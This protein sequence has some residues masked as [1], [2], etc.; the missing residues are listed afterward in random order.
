MTRVLNRWLSPAVESAR[1]A[2]TEASG[3][4]EEIGRGGQIF[5]R[6]VAVRRAGLGLSQE[7]LAARMDTSQP[8]VAGMEEGRPPSFDTLMR[9]ATALDVEP[10]TAAVLNSLGGRRLWGGLAIAVLAPVLVSVGLRSSGTDGGDSFRQLPQPV[11]AAP[12]APVVAAR[13]APVVGIETAAPRQDRGKRADEEAPADSRSSTGA[14]RQSAPQPAGPGGITSPRTP[15]PK[16]VPAPSVSPPQPSSQEG[17]S[18]PPPKP[19]GKPVDSPGNG[20]GGGNALGGATGPDG[21]T[22]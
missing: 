20:P 19:T 10:G 6:L 4:E 16:P 2:P 14:P 9:L 12:A 22:R 15:Q 5:G 7:D 8:N 11:S 17:P 1:P 13:A 21:Q 3:G 18:A